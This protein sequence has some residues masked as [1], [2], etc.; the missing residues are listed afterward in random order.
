MLL[1]GQTK[2][3]YSG[4]VRNP[5]RLPPSAPLLLLFAPHL[6]RTQRHAADVTL[7]RGR[8]G[9]GSW[10]ACLRRD[11]LGEGGRGEGPATGPPPFFVVLLL[12]VC[13]VL[14][15]SHIYPLYS[16]RPQIFLQ[17]S[18]SIAASGLKPEAPEIFNGVI[19]GRAG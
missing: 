15:L 10:A 9:A 16:L 18:G 13:S 5:P 12:F 8:C 6:R 4:A 11:W 17:L 1:L 14:T 3:V 19:S 2:R 7:W